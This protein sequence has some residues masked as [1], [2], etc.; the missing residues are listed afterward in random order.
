M[1]D[2]YG[3]ILQYRVLDKGQ[4]TTQ[5]AQRWP[6]KEIYIISMT[7]PNLIHRGQ[8]TQVAGPR[9]MCPKQIQ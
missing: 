3:E 5:V 4:E 2:F 7:H 1:E 6:Q 8:Y 9:H